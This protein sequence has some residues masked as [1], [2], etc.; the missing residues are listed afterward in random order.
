[1]KSIYEDMSSKLRYNRF[2]YNYAQVAWLAMT[3]PSIVVIWLNAG[4]SFSQILYLQGIFALMVIGLEFPSGIIEDL[5]E[6]KHVLTLG[7]LFV[8]AGAL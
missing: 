5:F 3:I 8:S 4:L 7:Y 6:R 1:M 2:V